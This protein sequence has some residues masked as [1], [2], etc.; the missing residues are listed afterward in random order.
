MVR[1]VHVQAEQGFDQWLRS[2]RQESYATLLS[3]SDAVY[4]A[5]NTVIGHSVTQPQPD[6]QSAA[7]RAVNTALREVDR[8]DRTVWT[9]G[10]PRVARAGLA[11]RH[12]LAELVDVWRAPGSLAH[13]QRAIAH[14]TAKDQ[15]GE[16]TAHLLEQVEQVIQ[17]FDEDQ[18]G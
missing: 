13:D 1:Q 17:T 10:P 18:P 8:A 15:W 6:E 16:A 9:V 2:H 5:L 7:W 12:A 14:A 3:A 11:M 4:D